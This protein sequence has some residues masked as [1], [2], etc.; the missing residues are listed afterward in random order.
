M[1]LGDF[2][3]Q[4][5][6]KANREGYAADKSRANDPLIKPFADFDGLKAKLKSL[7]ESTLGLC[8][9]DAKGKMIPY[10]ENVFAR[11]QTEIQDLTGKID[12][13]SKVLVELEAKVQE[14]GI[15]ED[16]FSLGRMHG[17]KRMLLERIE[18]LRTQPDKDL[19][20][21]W[22]AVLEVGGDRAMYEALPDVK[23]ARQKAVEQIKPLESEITVLDCQILA[24][25]TIL[26]KLKL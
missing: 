6:K 11:V 26:R 20:H 5:S 2:A 14:L 21:K 3:R 10:D 13:N 18:Q 25:E 9:L 22:K 17:E 12:H 1:R 7:Q 16:M 24:L 4:I 19:A 8:W 23:A 15:R